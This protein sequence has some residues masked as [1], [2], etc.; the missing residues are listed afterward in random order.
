MPAEATEAWEDTP[1]AQ[2]EA[3]RARNCQRS[4][5]SGRWQFLAL[6]GVSGLAHGTDLGWFSLAAL[7]TVEVLLI[8]FRQKPE[9]DVCPTCKE[10]IGFLPGRP[11]DDQMGLSDDVVCCP[12]CGEDFREAPSQVPAGDRTRANLP[13]PMRNRRDARGFSYRHERYARESGAVTPEVTAQPEPE[14]KLRG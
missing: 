12:Y 5:R 8:F 10:G 3:R 1:R 6:L 9:K 7:P 13:S 11:G 2:I 14:L 4:Q